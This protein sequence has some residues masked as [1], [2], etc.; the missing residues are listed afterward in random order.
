MTSWWLS[1]CDASRPTGS[2]FLGAVLV[3][4]ADMIDAIRAS[5]AL[6]I[7]PGGEVAGHAVDAERMRRVDDKWKNRLLTR[8]ECADMD[9][10]M[11][12]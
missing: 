11:L 7:N 9:R 4:G 12:S 8:E 10:E 1:F 2:Q 5:H 6:G 3:D